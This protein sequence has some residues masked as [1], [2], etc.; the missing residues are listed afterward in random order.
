MIRLD[1]GNGIKRGAHKW[2][3]R[4]QQLRFFPEADGFEEYGAA[5]AGR[6]R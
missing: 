1:V 2:K 6:V 4:E 3:N 5:Y